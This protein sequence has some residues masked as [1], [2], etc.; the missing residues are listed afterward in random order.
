MNHLHLPTFSEL[1]NLHAV[2]EIPA[3]TNHKYEY[4]KQ[5][6]QFEQDQRDGVPRM[7]RFLPYPVNYGFIPSTRMDKDRAGDG[8]PLDV[9][10]LAE[11]MPTGTLI[12]VL[13]IGLLKLKDTGE[14]DH[15]VLAVPVDP[16]LR[17]IDATDW[18][19]FQLYYSAIRHILETFFLYY[20][21]LG[22]MTLL[23]WGNATEAQQEVAK[24][25]F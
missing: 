6:L 15:K 24:W 11:S 16:A 20:D 9:L 14:L 10:L 25:R 12:E 4:N 7:V 5:L 18:N 17:I 21:G 22:T 23:G 2:I 1:G 8:D 19:S 3:G 13:P